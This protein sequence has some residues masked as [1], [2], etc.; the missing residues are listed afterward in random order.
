MSAAE[1][2]PKVLRW[3]ARFRR[4]LRHGKRGKR[5]HALT[6]AA[7]AT[8]VHVSTAHR[9]ADGAA[10]RALQESYDLQN[11]CGL[12]PLAN[13]TV[14]DSFTLAEAMFVARDLEAK[15]IAAQPLGVAPEVHHFDETGNFSGAVLVE[16]ARAH[17]Y[18]TYRL[19]KDKVGECGHARALVETLCLLV[20][21]RVC[22]VVWRE[23]T[24]PR[25]GHWLAASHIPTLDTWRAHKWVFKD[26]LCRNPIIMNSN[27]ILSKLDAAEKVC[28]DFFVVVDL[29]DQ[30]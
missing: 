28:A 6:V 9:G 10:M 16:L 14:D 11:D 29:R 7:A 3:L 12:C 25:S 8:E 22:G 30:P 23:G 19:A 26:S 4:R 24:N 21:G 17:G 18:G 27:G 1:R 5:S 20:P 15:L 2:L 13:V